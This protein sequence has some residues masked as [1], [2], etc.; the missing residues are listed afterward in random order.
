[1]SHIFISYSHQDSEYAHRLAK[2]LEAASFDVWIDGR[3]DFGTTWPRI[4]QENLDTCAA[5]IV[6]MTPRAY[7][8]DWVQNELNRAKR[9]GKP[10]F[11][12]LLEGDEPWLSVEALQ[13]VDVRGGDLPPPRFY[14]RLAEVSPVRRSSPI[15]DEYVSALPDLAGLLPTPF[16]WCY[17]PSGQTVFEDA[18]SDGGT[19][20]GMFQVDS[21][22][23]SKF[24]VT[25]AQYQTFVNAQDGYADERWW[26]Y[27]DHAYTWH[28][29]NPEP[30]PTAFDGEDDPRSNLCWYETIAFCGWLNFKLGLPPTPT[31]EEASIRLPSERQWQRAAQ[32]DDNRI[33]PWGNTFEKSRCNV[34]ESG[35]KRTTSVTRYPDGISPF[36]VMDMSGNI[37]E[38]CLTEWGS[39]NIN[40]GSKKPRPLRGGSWYFDKYSA[41]AAY[42]NWSNPEHRNYNIGSRLCFVLPID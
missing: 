7:E 8:S 16:E 2:A 12:L 20:G 28:S 37:W 41:R 18:S 9:K 38:W 23:I 5:F 31:H 15:A 42:R 26:H 40:I 39:S 33:Y 34:A 36:G 24:P 32:G 1:M 19:R 25:D 6:I 10:M 4:I 30:K 3:I 27:S 22:C 35:I 14:E 17:V 11:P 13:Y 21:F 29:T